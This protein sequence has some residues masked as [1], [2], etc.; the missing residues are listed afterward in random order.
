[1]ALGLHPQF[2][3][4]QKAAKKDKVRVG[5]IGTGYRGQSHIEMLVQR[6]DTEIGQF[7]L[8]ILVIADV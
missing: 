8:L 3:Q 7:F 4:A 5:I 2:A 1:M 6:K